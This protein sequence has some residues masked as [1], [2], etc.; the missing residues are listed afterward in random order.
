M[1]MVFFNGSKSVEASMDLMT[2]HGWLY[3]QRR[4]GNGKWCGPCPVMAAASE[5]SNNES[6]LPF[7]H[8]W[9]GLS[10]PDHIK[11]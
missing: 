1:E 4:I 10:T 8:W 11:G 3:D 6:S 2:H 7:L 5:A 9:A